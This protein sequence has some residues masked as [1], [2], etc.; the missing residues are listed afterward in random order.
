MQRTPP[1]A[2]TSTVLA[3]C[4]ATSFL[5]GQQPRRPPGEPRGSIVDYDAPPP[6]LRGLFLVVA[7]V[8]RGRVIS[9]SP[10]RYDV[11]GGRSIPL[12]AHDFQIDEVFK[13]D[14]V[15]V[16]KGAS[17]ITVIQHGG[18]IVDQ[19]GNEITGKLGEIYRPG[20]E[21]IVFLNVSPAAGGFTVAYG[22]SGGFLVMDREVSIPQGLRQ[23]AEFGGRPSIPTATF[24][25]LLRQLAVT[26]Q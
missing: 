12:T 16:P 21:L 14:P 18:T 8:V 19:D 9:S 23:Y 15:A 6:T 4:V 2:L 26:K 10:R 25:Q 13:L 1:P 3:F 24:V 22:P 17:N 20:Q 11:T 7:V 5:Y